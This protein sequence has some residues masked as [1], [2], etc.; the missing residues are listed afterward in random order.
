MN[1][2]LRKDDM[3]APAEREYGLFVTDDELC[4]RLGVPYHKARA[5]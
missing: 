3:K 2:P 4:K 1:K 5:R